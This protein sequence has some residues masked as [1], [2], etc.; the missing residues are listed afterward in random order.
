MD[1]QIDPDQAQML[2]MH[3]GPQIA[4]AVE[5]KYATP[6]DNDPDTAQ[7]A[8]ELCVQALNDIASIAAQENG[9]DGKIIEIITPDIKPN[10]ENE[11]EIWVT[12]PALG[13][14]KISSKGAFINS[15][16]LVSIAG[17]LEVAMGNTLPKLQRKPTAMAF[18]YA[19]RIRFTFVKAKQQ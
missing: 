15:G 19:I 14:Y 18:D 12:F 11:V 16:P 13:D 10:N 9:S 3:I 2:F 8:E 6:S 7:K 17:Y 1:T 5:S 4:H